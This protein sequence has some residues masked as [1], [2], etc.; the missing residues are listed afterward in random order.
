MSQS[1]EFDRLVVA[2]NPRAS[3]YRRISREVARLQRSHP[4]F[5]IERIPTSANMNET[6]DTIMDTVR[7][8]DVLVVI[9]GDGTVNQVGSVVTS[10]DFDRGDAPNTPFVPLRGGN[11]NDIANM[12][13]GRASLEE[14]LR[15]GEMMELF[16]LEVTVTAPEEQ[17]RQD[18]FDDGVYV[19]RALGYFSV[20]AAAEATR[21][22]D[23]IKPQSDIIRWMLRHT[24]IQQA[25]EVF[26][27]LQPMAQAKPVIAIEDG[28][29]P[30]ALV[31]ES[32]LRGDRIAKYG[33][34]HADLTK[35]IFERT[36]VYDQGYIAALTSMIKMQQG[37]LEGEK[38]DSVT[39]LLYGRDGKPIL[40]QYD[41]EVI[42][43]PSGSTVNVGIAARGYH[44]LTTKL[45]TEVD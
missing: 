34:P 33:H 27:V 22:L 2:E 45:A 40:T 30:Y 6:H 24:G 13:N 37:K 25:R 35:Q 28:Y 11:A 12:I 10:Q 3:H 41:G 20:H 4:D 14:I 18:P 29:P 38:T 36:R 26:A 19:R 16:P 32:F 8:G 15:R 43:I 7:Q 44:T 23:N 9:G 42:E 17:T 5:G 39:Q 1:Y 21:G 31:D